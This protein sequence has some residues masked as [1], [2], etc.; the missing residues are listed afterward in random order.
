MASRSPSA[1]VASRRPCSSP[2]PGTAAWKNARNTGARSAASSPPSIRLLLLPLRNR[3]QVDKPA[4]QLDLSVRLPGS[5]IELVRHDARAGL[6]LGEQARAQ[7]H[8][9]IRQQVQR[10]HRRIAELRLEEVLAPERN[11]VGDALLARILVGFLDALRVDVDA[12]GT[13]AEAL[14][15][16]HR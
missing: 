5:H 4:V 12:D 14:G 16:G 7:L 15:G 10:D 11:E 3:P 1:G 13:D 9:E 2:A 8:V 6:E